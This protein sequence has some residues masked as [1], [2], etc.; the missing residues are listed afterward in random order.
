MSHLIRCL[1][2]MAS[3]SR[4]KTSCCDAFFVPGAPNEISQGS[5]INH[6]PKKV[7]TT[8]TQI[9]MPTRFYPQSTFEPNMEAL[10]ADNSELQ[11]RLR[12]CEH[13]LRR[14]DKQYRKLKYAYR[15]LQAMYDALREEYERVRQKLY[16]YQ[17]RFFF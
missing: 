5:P 10:R 9:P 11:R 14:K 1:P 4:C 6:K 15:D 7:P 8:Q 16:R 12:Y 3:T 17:R 2:C 13:E